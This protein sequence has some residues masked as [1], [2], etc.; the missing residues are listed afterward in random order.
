MLFPQGRHGLHWHRVVH[1]Q[2]QATYYDAEKLGILLLGHRRIGSYAYGPG[3]ELTWRDRT[4]VNRYSPLASWPPE[5]M[6]SLI[7][8]EQIPV[9]P[10][11]SWP[12]A[13]GPTPWSAR[14]GTKS[15]W[16]GFQEVWD[17]AR[18]SS[19]TP[20]PTYPKPNSGSERRGGRKCAEYS[21]TSP[22]ATPYPT[23]GCCN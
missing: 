5:A 8:R 23:N 14:L 11:Y 3:R 18:T 7:H 19:A 16:H 9:P 15:T 10:C 20:H 17:I 1:Q 22:T 2:G 12:R 6:W 21:D 13:L 4:G